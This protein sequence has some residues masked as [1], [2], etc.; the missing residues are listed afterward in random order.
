MTE[1]DVINRELL[2]I[3]TY[4]DAPEPSGNGRATSVLEPKWMAA[5]SHTA[6]AGEESEPLPPVVPL[7]EIIV[8]HPKLRRPVIHGL[9]REGE[10]V[11]VVAAPKQGKSWFV[12]GLMVSAV[13]GSTWLDSFDCEQGR[14]LLI[15]G[16]LHP[17]TIAH[18]LPMVAEAM[19]FGIDCLDL[20]DVWALRGQSAD[21]YKLAGRLGEIEPGIYKLI[22]LDAWYRF[23]PPDVSENDNAGVMSLYNRIDAYASRL[24]AAW[25]NVHH[26]SKGSQAEKSIT[27]VGSGAGSQSRAADTHLVIRPHEEEGVAV[28]EAVVRSWPPVD[29][30]AIRFDFPIWTPAPDADPRRL[31]TRRPRTTDT[32]DADRQEIVN[33]IHEHGP[34]TK[35][36][37]L[38]FVSFG[39]TR[40]DKALASLANDD[41]LQVQEG[42][43]K[44][45]QKY[46]FWGIKRDDE[47]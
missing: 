27:D 41:T 30:M 13:T 16:E 37:L 39:H 12:D 2:G 8:N 44:Q 18:R 3:S 17:E 26:A 33:V 36:R 20:I 22:V 19:G 42:Q 7:R 43:G 11:N 9:L 10:T 40:L 29:P 47:S 45:G 38:T 14:V 23:L 28:L 46:N 6:N 32:L 25:V 4:G 5:G 24:G 34:L 15:D 35:S 31:A 1:I 21:L